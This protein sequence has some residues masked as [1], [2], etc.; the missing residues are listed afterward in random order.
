MSEAI[1]FPELLRRA[2]I[3]LSWDRKPGRRK[4]HR[5][6]V[7]AWNADPEMQAKKRA[8][9]DAMNERTR[10]ARTAWIIAFNRRPG[11]VLPPMSKK[12]HRRYR[13]LRSMSTREHALEAVMAERKE[14]RR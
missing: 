9:L 1:E 13:Y 4:Y 14:G 7:E 2:R 6:L 3:S 10:E 12:E 11:H 8:H 5:K